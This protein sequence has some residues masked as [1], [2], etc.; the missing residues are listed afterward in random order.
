MA[1]CVA[2]LAA[3]WQDANHSRQEA[4]FSKEAAE[5]AERE[6]CNASKEEGQ[7][8]EGVHLSVKHACY[9]GVSAFPQELFMSADPGTAGAANTHCPAGIAANCSCQVKGVSV[10]PISSAA[11]VC[12]LQQGL[13]WLCQ[14]SGKS[15]MI[16]PDP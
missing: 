5:E 15:P 2:G 12:M 9:S 8:R 13:C 11:C 14:M 10:V 7:E 16:R 4:S 1:T 6:R 3:K